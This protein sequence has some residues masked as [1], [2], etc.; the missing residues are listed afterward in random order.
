ML[1][2]LSPEAPV[3]PLTGG[4]ERT[5]RVLGYLA[6]RGPVWALTCASDDEAPYLAGLPP[7]LHLPRLP[8]PRAR[9]PAG[10]VAIAGDQC[11]IYPHAT[12]GGWRLVGRTPLRLFDAGR[13]PPGL[14]R[15]GDR[16]AIRPIDAATFA[17]LTLAEGGLQ[18]MA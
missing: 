15:A 9:V 4:R 7:E 3:P 1:L 14:L 8:S 13:E 17:E 2:H 12:P 16:V 11:G 6:A 18:E 10:S 5:R